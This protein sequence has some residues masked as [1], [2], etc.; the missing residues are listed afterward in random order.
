MP[1]TR[2]GVGGLVTSSDDGPIR[3]VALVI[4]SL[5]SNCGAGHPCPSTRTYAQ[6]HYA[7]DTGSGASCAHPSHAQIGRS[8]LQRQAIPSGHSMDGRRNVSSPPFAW[9]AR[10]E[11]AVW[12]LRSWAWAQGNV[13]CLRPVQPRATTFKSSCVGSARRSRPLTPSPAR[14]GSSGADR[15]QGGKRIRRQFDGYRLDVLAQVLDRG[16]ARDQQD[17]G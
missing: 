13:R 10:W 8:P 2:T 16:C 5:T 14:S 17:V 3:V 6:L 15:I 4:V 11:H 9:P 12:R 1:S 7:R